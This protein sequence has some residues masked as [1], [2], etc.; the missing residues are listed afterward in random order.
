MLFEEQMTRNANA[1]G[2][3]DKD[4]L[5]QI[6]P[7]IDYFVP[8]KHRGKKKSA[9]T[10]KILFP[11]YAD[12]PEAKIAC[13][14]FRVLQQSY[15]TWNNPLRSIILI[16]EVTWH[17]SPRSAFDSFGEAL[18]AGVGETFVW[19]H[20]FRPDVKLNKSQPWSPEMTVFFNFIERAAW[21]THV[22]V[23]MLPC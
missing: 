9:L 19:Y 23:I 13:F 14:P 21:R 4:V 18:F 7:V 20:P 3:M 2:L 22:E 1:R 8:R 15:H 12:F 5:S 10:K 16:Q 6:S 17:I 11:H